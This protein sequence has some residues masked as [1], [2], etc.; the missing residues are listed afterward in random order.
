MQRKM[1]GYPQQQQCYG[2]DDGM[3]MESKGQMQPQVHHYQDDSWSNDNN[4]QKQLF[5][6][7]MHMKPA[8]NFGGN[9]HHMYPHQETMPAAAVGYG[10]QM[11]G[12][13]GKQFPYG[14]TH[15]HSPNGVRPFNL[16]EY[17]Y[18]AYKEEH[19]GGSKKDEMRYERHGYGNGGDVRYV[20]SYEYNNNF[21]ARIKPHAHGP[22]KVNWTLKGV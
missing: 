9:N 16:E 19:V 22:H 1:Q 18:E 6:A 15:N 17:E 5:P 7:A 4:N 21:N 12:N 3:W 13:G 2:S 20:N 8:A 14:G 11:H 10:N